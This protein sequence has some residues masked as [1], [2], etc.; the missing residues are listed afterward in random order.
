MDEERKKN[1]EELYRASPLEIVNKLEK[2]EMY[3]KKSSQE[4]I[5]E[6]YTEFQSSEHLTDSILKPVFLSII[7]GF[8]EATAGGKAARKK[9]LTASRVLNECEEFSYDD[10]MQ[11]S[12]TVNGY[13]E[14]KNARE[15]DS[16][17][18]HMEQQY[19]GE[20]RSKLYEDKP[21]MTKYKED[22]VVGDKTLIDEYT[23]KRNL[24]L[25]KDNPNQHYNDETHRKQAQP[26]HIVPLK[27]VHDKFKSN[28]ALDDT[29]IKRIANIEENFA[30]TSAEINQVKK[31]MTNK[32]Y[33][34]WMEEN[35]E[36]VDEKTKNNM[37]KLQK[38]AEKSVD[39]K[40]NETIKDNLMG[41]GGVNAETFK[42]HIEK[43][44]EENGRTPTPK[45]KVD[46]ETKLKKEKTKE[47]Y[48]TAMGNAAQQSK[49]YAVGN[50]ML[51]I[52]KPLYYEMK[53]IFKN[54]MTE[55]VG[56][57]STLEALKIRFN[58]VTKH[59]LI[60]AKG[61]LGDNIW[62]FVKGF[63]S[64]LI[65]GIISLFVGVFKQVLKLIKEG[66][67]IFVQSAKILFGKDAKEMTSAQKG[68]A[69]IKLIGGSVIAISGIA[70]ES[71][72]NKIGIGEPWSAVL[73]TMLSGIAS[74]L[75]MYLL[76]KADLFSTKAEKRRDRINEIFDERIREIKTVAEDFN[77]IAIETL[78]KQRQEFEE[79]A[80]DI[81]EGLNN[82]SIDTINKNL[83]KMADFY[84]VDLPYTN[85]SDFV[86]Y[87]DSEEAIEL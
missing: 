9:G 45:E 38:K 8:L 71:L 67:K 59:V 42:S 53:D 32:Q 22:R 72:L 75:F 70:I 81:T 63:V 26:D 35:R 25:K 3:D 14:Y 85:T 60:N 64:S 33:I 13:T 65:E 61:F 46:I 87:F 66:I 76:D 23:G 49:D 15:F 19:S 54:G 21:A 11:N 52:V 12:T 2:F 80:S 6:V 27:Q 1:L 5:D 79:I 36:K 28:Y 50:L 29:D 86:E 37:L 31:E 77:V 7:D 16:I 74:A 10:K 62:E 83:Y 56:T 69:I 44:K 24:Y 30:V 51:F 48:G 43:F 68:D 84:K 57:D 78:R 34:Q 47:I 17:N 20:A 39:D 18:S 55:G 82:N 4:I 73:S 41:N 58:R 40:A